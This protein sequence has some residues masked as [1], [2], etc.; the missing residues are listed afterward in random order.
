MRRYQEVQQRLK[1]QFRK[2]SN[3]A[4]DLIDKIKQDLVVRGIQFLVPCEM[5][6]QASGKTLDLSVRVAQHDRVRILTVI[7]ENFRSVAR[8]AHVPAFFFLT[9]TKLFYFAVTRPRPAAREQRSE[10][11]KKSF[12]RKKS[13]NEAKSFI[14]RSHARDR[15]T[16]DADLVCGEF[17]PPTPPGREY[18]P[19]RAPPAAPKF[20]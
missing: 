3:R 19:P 15:A 1:G 8:F 16:V 20:L 6:G 17:D 9:N 10:N 4:G 13:S 12:H 11:L 5:C 18:R 14:S 2:H 7:Q